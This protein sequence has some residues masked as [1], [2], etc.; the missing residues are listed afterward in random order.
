[1]ADVNRENRFR[2][3][4]TVNRWLFLAVILGMVAVY[5]SL[6]YVAAVSQR[7]EVGHG[8][9]ATVPVVVA[10][11]AIGAFTPLVP[12]DVVIKQFPQ[13]LAPPDALSSLSGI[14]GAWTTVAVAP[15]MPVS[16]SAVFFPKTSDVLASRIAPKDLAVDVPL[17]S[18][19][20]IDGLI[21]PGDRI[22]LFNTI[23]GSATTS[24]VEDFMNNIPV[25]GVN[26]LLTPSTT[27]TI[28]QSITLI[29]ALPASRIPQLIYAEQQGKL[30]AAL[31]PPH[32]SAS[33][34][35]PYTTQMYLRPV[36]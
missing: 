21:V 31:D 5:L 27:S 24:V 17:T 9:V 26:G 22:T 7:T 33:I 15:G 12:Q 16:L 2:Q 8:N 14:S 29:L 18:V 30:V 35:A 4:I 19:N 3:V 6:Q 1:M 13:N 28:G 20:A 36:P 25:L 10:Q 11:S 32:S 23:P 34:P